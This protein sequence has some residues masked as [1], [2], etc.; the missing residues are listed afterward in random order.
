MTETVR[1]KKTFTKNTELTCKEIKFIKGNLYKI[2]FSPEACYF[3]TY[4]EKDGITYSDKIKFPWTF[5]EEHFEIPE[6]IK[7]IRDD[8]FAVFCEFF[9]SWERKFLDLR[10]LEGTWKMFK[11]SK[12]WRP[13]KNGIY[14]T[15]RAGL[16]GIY[17]VL[18]EWKDNK[19]QV[20]AADA[21]YTIYFDPEPIDMKQFGYE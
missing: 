6:E 7:R 17:S 11:E 10:S 13:E 4:L 15:I 21:S 19:W 16:G 12:G 20:E 8:K 3:N 5:S 1:C 18:N 2:N 9:R 14:K